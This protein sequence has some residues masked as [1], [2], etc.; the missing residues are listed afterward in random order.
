MT[1]ERSQSGPPGNFQVRE[2]T[3]ATFEKEVIKSARLTYVLFYNTS[4]SACKSMKA[5]LNQ[6]GIA[7]KERIDFVQVDV[8]S[9]Q[10]FA[11]KYAAGNGMPCSVI[12]SPGG[13]IIR[14]TRFPDG[15]SVW[16]GDA[17]N[18]Q[19]FINWLNNV[20]NVANENW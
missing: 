13:N 18:L 2:V 5:T 4:C 12:L 19:Y 8:A 17:H 14:D 1:A 11:S 3:D 16:V 7:F 10:A 20:L 6:I 15:Q 9:N